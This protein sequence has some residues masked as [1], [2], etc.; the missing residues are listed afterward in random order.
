[1]SKVGTGIYVKVKKI[2][3]DPDRDLQIAL[4]EFNRKVKEDGL[5][6]EIKQRQFYE[7][8]SSVR[9]RKRRAA[10]RREEQRTEKKK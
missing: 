6:Y 2:T 4:R 8:P 3:G 5:I 9:R 7:K 10:R 1:M